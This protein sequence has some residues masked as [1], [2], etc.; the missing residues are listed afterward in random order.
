MTAITPEA[1]LAQPRVRA[2][3]FAPLATLARR[4]FQLIAR[5]PR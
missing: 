5:T 1:V 4:R 2:N 3:P